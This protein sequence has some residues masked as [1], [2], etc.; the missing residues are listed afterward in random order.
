MNF[1]S[2][3]GGPK[4]RLACDVCRERKVRCDRADPRCGRCARLGHR[5]TYYGRKSYR[6]ALDPDLPRRLSELQE[7]LS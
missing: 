3:R 7:R 2:S 4:A 1:E 6:A 5:C